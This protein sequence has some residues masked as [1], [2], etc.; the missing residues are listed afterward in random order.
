MEEEL[1]SSSQRVVWPPVMSPCACTIERKPCGPEETVSIER[2][3]ASLSYVLQYGRDKEEEMID[4]IIFKKLVPNI[5]SVKLDWVYV[6]DVGFILF[7]RGKY[8]RMNSSWERFE[9]SSIMESHSV[10]P[11]Q[12]L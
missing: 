4:L 8:G 10:S 3:K 12:K 9:L 11:V 2:F 6:P 7:F 1:S 5:E